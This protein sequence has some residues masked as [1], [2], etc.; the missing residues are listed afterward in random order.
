MEKYRD[1]VDSS[2]GVNP[3]PPLY[4]KNPNGV[5]RIINILVGPFLALARMA[6]FLALLLIAFVASIITGILGVIPVVGRLVQRFLDALV[7]RTMLLVLGVFWIE[8]KDYSKQ[9]N[10]DRKAKPQGVA[11]Q[12]GD[13]IVCNWTSYADVMYL[14]YAFGPMFAFPS[15]ELAEGADYK[16]ASKSFFGALM[17]SF[18]HAPVKAGQPIEAAVQSA[19]GRGQPLVLFAEGARTNGLAVV[20]MQPFMKGLVKSFK[21]KVFLVGF[22]H[23]QHVGALPFPAGSAVRHLFHVSRQLFSRM[24]VAYMDSRC[25]PSWTADDKLDAC[26]GLS[27]ACRDTISKFVGLPLKCKSVATDKEGFLAFFNT[28]KK[29]RK[30]RKGQGG[31][32]IDNEAGSKNQKGMDHAVLRAQRLASK[33]KQIE[34]E[35]AEDYDSDEAADDSD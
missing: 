13:V 15:P 9:A 6:V 35:E 4:K 34:D 16:V 12:A 18:S 7:A 3:W 31:R 26:E 19:R 29:E 14:A 32:A 25:V 33:K 20:A 2:T 8:S 5:L 21:G 28:G 11:V 30:T 17:S 27:T 22:K 23:Q 24:K 1:W 10:R